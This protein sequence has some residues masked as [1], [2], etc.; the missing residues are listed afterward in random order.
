MSRDTKVVKAAWRSELA[1]ARERSGGREYASTAEYNGN[2]RHAF[3]A[4]LRVDA[5][6]NGVAFT[7][8][9]FV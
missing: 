7:S 6:I 9:L 5:G 2:A 8:Q 3:A 1:T 4:R